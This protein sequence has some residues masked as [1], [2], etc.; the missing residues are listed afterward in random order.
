MKFL[1]MIFLH[2]V[3]DFYFQK[4]VFLPMGSKRNGGGSR[5]DLHTNTDLI[6]FLH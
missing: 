4:I 5:R 3:D 1:L 2:I 6:T